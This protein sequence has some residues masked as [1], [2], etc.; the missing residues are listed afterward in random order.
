MARRERNGELTPYDGC[1]DA[2]FGIKPLSVGWLRRKQAFATGTVS[3]EY[4]TA[5]LRFCHPGAT[6]CPNRAPMPCPLCGAAV[7]VEID[8]ET[9]RLGSAEI[10]VIGDDEIYAAPDLIYHFTAAHQYLPP[11]QFV[12]AVV[13]G[14]EPDSA[15][16]RALINALNTIP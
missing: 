16:F 2:E 8:G 14:P 7:A 15:E 13:H 5:L 3:A 11:A 4:L 6:V 12:E 10:R 1:I 9:V